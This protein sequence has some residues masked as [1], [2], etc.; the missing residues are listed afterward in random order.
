MHGLPSS[1]RRLVI[2][3]ID[4]TL[5][6]SKLSA[7]PTTSVDFSQYS[8]ADHA[9]MYLVES[10][11][12]WLCLFYYPPHFNLLFITEY[13]ITTSPILLQSTRLCGAHN[14]NHSLSCYPCE[15]QLR[16]RTSLLHRESLNF[17]NDTF[18]LVKILALKLWYSTTEIVLGKVVR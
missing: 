12:I 9:L 3:D 17:V 7:V 10:S 15:G 1:F 8:V 2:S 4:E 18:V 6:Q 13:H 14:W 16:G 11:T 5:R